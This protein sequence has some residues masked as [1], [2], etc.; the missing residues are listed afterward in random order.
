M[1]KRG[2]RKPNIYI[3]ILK[4]RH[5]EY[6]ELIAKTYLQASNVMEHK[7]KD[8]VDFI[9]KA[10]RYSGS[11]LTKIE[12]IDCMEYLSNSFFSSTGNLNL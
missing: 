6:I 11:C 5:E 7:Y 8:E 1:A 3:G 4:N 12:S 9:Y 2:K 10:Q